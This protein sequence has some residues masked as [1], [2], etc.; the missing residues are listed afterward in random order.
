MC[1]DCIKRAEPVLADTHIY[2][3]RM[4]STLSE[5]QAYLQFFDD[6]ADL[7]RQMVDGYNKIYHPNNAALGL[8]TMRA[9]VTHWQGGYIEVGHGMVC[10]AYAILMITHGP[11][12]PITKD[13]EAMRMQTEMEFRMFKQNEYVYHSMREAALKNRP[14]TMMNEPMSVQDNIKNLFH[15]KK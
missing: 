7:S 6:A 1:R 13:L 3:L 15:R 4:Y 9:G 10:K 14:M 2:L 8:A 12:H 11:T 5:V